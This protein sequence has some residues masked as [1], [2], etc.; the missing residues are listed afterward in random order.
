M[1]N[2]PFEIFFLVQNVPFEIWIIIKISNEHSGIFRKRVIKKLWR[3]SCVRIW[4]QK[5]FFHR[6]NCS[7]D[8]VIHAILQ[9][10]TQF[11]KIKLSQNTTNLHTCLTYVYKISMLKEC[12]FRREIADI[13]RCNFITRGYKILL[14]YI[15]QD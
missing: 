6:Q 13:K 14:H 8:E 3:H 7:N 5:K 12:V 2:V 1:T 4:S 11:I 9:I 15:N 10:R